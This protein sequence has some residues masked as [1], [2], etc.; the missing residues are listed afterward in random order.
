MHAV[1]WQENAGTTR[2]GVHRVTNTPELRPFLGRRASDQT[3]LGSI[4]GQIERAYGTGDYARAAEVIE[5]EP[6]GAWFGIAPGRL[7]EIIATLHEQGVPVGGFVRSVVALLAGADAAVAGTATG[8]GAVGV[9]S[10]PSTP[11]VSAAAEA[12]ARSVGE[13]TDT[14]AL[15][16]LVRAFALRLQGRAPE[17]LRLLDELGHQGEAMQVLVDKYRGWGLFA[18][19][20]TG[21]TAMLAGDFV[22]AFAALTQARMHPL[23]PELAFL[24]RDACVK[25]ALL[26]ALYGDRT[27]AAGLLVE[28][29]RMPRTESWAETGIDAVRTLTEALLIDGPTEAMVAAIDAVPLGELQEMWPFYLVA[30]HRTLFMG[31]RLGEAQQRVEFFASLLLPVVTGEGYSGSALPLSAALNAMAIGDFGE[32]R[33]RIAMADQRLAVVHVVAA[34]IELAAGSPRGALT[35][36]HG[37]I[38]GIRGL[39]TLEVW[40]LAVVAGAHLAL[41]ESAECLE[42]L[43]LTTEQFGGLRPEELYFFTTESRQLGAAHVDAWPSARPGAV[44][45]SLFPEVAEVLTSR[46]LELLRELAGGLT[47]DEIAKL[48]FI[49]LNT[50]KAH[51]RSVYRKLGVSSRSAAIFEAE[52]RG[53]L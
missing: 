15:M 42:L 44:V 40:R 50:L 27:R 8:E 21:L 22:R 17:A 43:R 35:Q 46:E 52:R 20:Q 30:A 12:N 1:A 4:I 33:A 34:T 41:G 37:A 49:T 45:H 31:D 19:V 13:P 23:V 16:P 29:N 6:L 36:V 7:T 53:I 11:G 47:R 9:A 2:A 32:A 28:A 39:R 38:D 14:P 5:R 24:S 10:G 51:V 26:E 18:S 48:H 25:T 3:P